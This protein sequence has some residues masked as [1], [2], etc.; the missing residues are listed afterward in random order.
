MVCTYLTAMQLCYMYAHNPNI[1]LHMKLRSKTASK[2]CLNILRVVLM[3]VTNL[4]LG[5]TSAV[6]RNTS[7]FAQYPL[8]AFF[9]SMDEVKSSMLC[10]Q[11]WPTRPNHI[12]SLSCIM[13]ISCPHYHLVT[14]FNI[15]MHNVNIACAKICM[16][17]VLRRTTL[18]L[19]KSKVCI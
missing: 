9:V 5:Q 16:I 8:L 11:P 3:T 2:N 13:C 4:Q 15:C 14:D 17:K 19:P 18:Q 1:L 10:D 7:R 12:L 6:C